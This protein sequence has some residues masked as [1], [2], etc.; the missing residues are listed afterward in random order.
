MF[1]RIIDAAG[2]C[3]AF[4]NKVATC[5]VPIAA[6]ECNSHRGKRMMQ[7]QQVLIDDDVVSSRLLIL[8]PQNLNLAGA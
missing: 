4:E 7:N 1:P 8:L 5:L 6:I 3:S 2:F